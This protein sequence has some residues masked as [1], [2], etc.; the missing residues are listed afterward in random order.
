MTRGSVMPPASDA[1]KL[2]GYFPTLIDHPN[3]VLEHCTGPS[4]EGVRPL[5]VG[6][7]LSGGQAPGEDNRIQ[8]AR[9]DIIQRT[10]G[11]IP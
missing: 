1:D 3:V 9:N 5:N 10:D 6:I 2:R 4:A 7:V 11:P 8:T